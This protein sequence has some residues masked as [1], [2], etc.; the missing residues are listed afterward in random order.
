MEPYEVLFEREGVCV[1]RSPWGPEDNIGRLNLMTAQS[2]AA[3]VE[4][5]ICLARLRTVTYSPS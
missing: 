5:L 3:G 1:S 2:R 4:K